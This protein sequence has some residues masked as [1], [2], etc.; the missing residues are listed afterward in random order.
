MQH[1]PYDDGG[2]VF[3]EGSSQH[4]AAGVAYQGEHDE[5]AYNDDVDD[6]LYEI[7]ELPG[8]YD[9]YRCLNSSQETRLPHL[10]IEVNSDERGNTLP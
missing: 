2:Y 4:A 5:Y 6:L 3:P 7:G 1:N 9:A 8:S 10:R